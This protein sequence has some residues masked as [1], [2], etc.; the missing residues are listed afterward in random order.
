MTR[1]LPWLSEWDLLDYVDGRLDPERRRRVEAMLAHN[2]AAAA[3]VAA[4]LAIMEGLRRLFSPLN[5]R[6][7]P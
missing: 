6:K 4:D 7:V 3:R 5:A 2:P 1:V